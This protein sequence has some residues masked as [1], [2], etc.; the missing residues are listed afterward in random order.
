MIQAKYKTFKRALFNSYQS[1]KVKK[2]GDNQVV[3]GLINPNV[4][5][6]NYDDKI[7]SIGYEYGYKCGD[8]FQWVGTNTHWLIY[9]QDMTELAY[10]KG[11][12]RKCSYEVKWENENGELCSTWLAVRG[13]VETKIDSAQKGGIIIDSPNHSLNIL[14]P[15]NEETV[16]YFKR[17]NKFYLEGICWRVEATD[18]IS[19]P[20]ILE[21]TALEYYANETED[22]IEEG[23]VGGNLEVVPV[24]PAG[25]FI[26][27]E[28]F[29]KPKRQYIYQYLGVEEDTWSVD[30]NAP[31]EL[32]I[33]GNT[34]KLKWTQNFSGEF[35]LKYGTDEK[36]IVVE[37]LF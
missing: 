23:I 9:L 25:D 5:K 10:F 35:A 7:L 3:R 16:A 21:I 19:T 37:S 29:I 32:E 20:G 15:K 18:Y 26:M 14:M 27:G 36:T 6:Q 2:V 4:T 11:D 12:I 24:E 30:T 22:N 28:T 13:P 17:Y 34:V 8:V 31:V 1:A 33:Q